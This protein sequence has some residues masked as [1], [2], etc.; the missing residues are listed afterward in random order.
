MKQSDAAAQIDFELH[1]IQAVQSGSMEDAGMILIGSIQE[2]SRDA[3]VRMYS[4]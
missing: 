2:T 3:G 1:W 4:E